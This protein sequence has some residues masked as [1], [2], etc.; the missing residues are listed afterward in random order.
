MKSILVTG[1]NGF[2][3]KRL[4]SYLEVK[5]FKVNRVLR[6]TSNS[7]LHLYALESDYCFH[8]AGEVRPKATSHDF[9]SSNLTFTEQLISVL[10]SKPIDLVLTSTV[11]AANPSN[12]YGFTKKK[13]EDLILSYGADSGSH[14]HIY[15]LPHM[16]GPGCKPNYNSVISTWIVNAIQGAELVVFDKNI[17]MNYMYVDDLIL[18]FFEQIDSDSTLALP[19]TY[20]VT[21]G[22]LSQ[23]I[24][25]IIN[26]CEVERDDEFVQKLK[27]TIQDYQNIYC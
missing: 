11:H 12:D 5:G 7:D 9:L 15:R 25:S 16:F 13:S 1:A 23:L 22:E 18:T 10:N 3:G 20:K 2:I 14:T 6:E 19:V 24:F 17:E 21:L 26:G 4:C 27:L 8:L